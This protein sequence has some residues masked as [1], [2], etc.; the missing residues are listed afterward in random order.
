MLG[1]DVWP[2]AALSLPAA[3]TPATTQV[4]MTFLTKS[5]VVTQLTLVV[6]ITV[7]RSS[8]SVA[9]EPLHR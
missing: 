2:R 5:Q 3:P 7:L 9:A 4:V 8:C 6:A 1:F